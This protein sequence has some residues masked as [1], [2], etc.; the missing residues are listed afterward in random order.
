MDKVSVDLGKR[1]S[2]VKSKRPLPRKWSEPDWQAEVVRDTSALWRIVVMAG[3][4]APYKTIRDRRMKADG[5]W[6]RGYLKLLAVMKDA[7]TFEPGENDRI[8]CN[9]AHAGNAERV[10]N[11]AKFSELR[12]DTLSALKFIARSYGT[13]SMPAGMSQLLALKQSRLP[14]SSSLESDKAKR[15]RR[16]ATELEKKTQDVRNATKTINRLKALLFASQLWLL[17]SDARRGR[18][19]EL[20]AEALDMLKTLTAKLGL[21]R[22][23]GFGKAGI[24]TL[25]EDWCEAFYHSLA[26][27]KTTEE[28]THHQPTM[29]PLSVS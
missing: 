3:N 23:E 9:L 26:L 29:S 19:T 14:Q 22:A 10:K 20:Q 24:N 18:D 27:C 15:D 1:S 4:L 12:V 7:L 16:R 13:E 21:H 28:A 2:A 17:G 6:R 25:T 11:P 8:Y 5:D